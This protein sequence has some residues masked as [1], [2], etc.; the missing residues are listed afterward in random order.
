MP[1]PVY[2][3]YHRNCPDGLAASWV[4]LHCHKTRGLGT[5]HIT[6]IPADAGK[7]PTNLSW[8]DHNVVMLD[9]SFK[10][11]D[12]LRIASEAANIFIIDHHQ[13]A[14]TDLSGEF[15]ENVFLTFDMSKCGAQLAWDKW[16]PGRDYP[17]FIDVIADRDLWLWKNPHSKA[18]GRYFSEYGYFDSHDKFEELLTWNGNDIDRSVEIG[19]V[20]LETDQKIVKLYTKSAILCDFKTPEKT[21]KVY[22]TG[23]P[24]QYASEVGHSLS[25]K[26]E[27]DFAVMWRYSFSEDEWQLSCRS[28]KDRPDIDLSVICSKFGSGGGHKQAAGFTLK[29]SEANLHSYLTKV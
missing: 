21:Y 22:L 6:L 5:D 15:P 11:D 10:K 12:L 9:I 18:I 27:C 3:I 1:F 13:T 25:S 20:L 24:H 4:Y 16:F 19:N 29:N 17:W 26:S 8:K 2:L 14:Q 23:C 28:S 7:V